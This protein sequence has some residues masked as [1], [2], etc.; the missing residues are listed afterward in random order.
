MR[1][2][3][4]YGPAGNTWTDKDCGEIPLCEAACDGKLP[5]VKELLAKPGVDVDEQSRYGWTALHW[6]AIKGHAAVVGVLLAAGARTDLKDKDGDT[7][8]M[9]RAM[10]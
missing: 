3:A 5:A 1:S 2:A 8:T 10:T 6:A 9:P 4:K 7:W